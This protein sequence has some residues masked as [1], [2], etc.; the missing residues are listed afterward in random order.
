MEHLAGES[1]VERLRRGPVPLAQALEIAA[2]VAEALDAAHKHGIVHRDL[3]P[4]NVMLTTGG[5]GRSGA[6]SAKLLD[7]GLAK[8][9]GH[10][11]R[12]ALAGGVSAPTMTAPIT[13]RGT[14][15]GTLQYMAPEQLEGKEADARTDLWALGAILYE[16]V[17]GR[18][19]FE[20]ESQVSLIGNIMNA[21]PA[22][23]ATLQPLTPPA[24]DRVVKKCL[25]K[26]PDDRWDTAHDVADDLRW[27]AEERRLTQ[28]PAGGQ[29]PEIT[30]GVSHARRGRRVRRALALGLGAVVLAGSGAV[31][32]W[33]AAR[34]SPA[35]PPAVTRAFIDVRPAERVE[36]VPALTRGGSRTAL[37]ITQDGKRLVF[38]G[39]TGDVSRLYVRALDGTMA[40]E[41]KGT[42][43]AESPVFSPDGRWIAFW[44]G[45]GLKKVQAG[46]GP[47]T[48][49]CRID[50]VDPPY[51]ISWADDG[52][53]VFG[54]LRGGLMEVSSNGGTPSVLTKLQPG[55]VSHRLPCVMPGSQ[56]VL[57]TVRRSAWLWGSEE[58]VA[59]SLVTGERR[60]V[61]V[62]GTDARYVPT[63]H[64]VYLQLGTLMARAFDPDGLSVSGPPVGLVEQVAQSVDALTE[65]HVSGAGQYAVSASGTLV[66]LAGGIASPPR[67]ALVALDRTG[68]ITTLPVEPSTFIFSPVMS[69]DGKTVA[70]PTRDVTQ[71]GLWLIDVARGTRTR[72]VSEGE[73]FWPR[74]TPDG[75]RVA[76]LWRAGGTMSVAWVAADS[77]APP[78]R[79]V[80]VDAG[81]SLAPLSWSPDGRQ[82]VINVLQ[83]NGNRDISLLSLNDPKRALQPLIHTSA[84][85]INA[86]FSPDGKWLAYASNESGRYEVY[87][88]AH[89]PAGRRVAVSTTGA[90]NP[91]W[92]P[93]GRELFFVSEPDR[94]RKRWLMSARFTA[95]P[96][97]SVG[98]PRALFEVIFR[99]GT[100]GNGYDVFPDGERFLTLR[101]LPALP[102]AP[103]TEITL[104]DHWFEELKTK[105]PASGKAK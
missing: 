55:E 3:K 43:G 18:R 16:M 19:A 57:F 66:Y 41:L 70:V 60:V 85:E 26:H 53:I 89:P 83:P 63:G 93:N 46:G 4:G 27:I 44:A 25:A 6:V 95:R 96:K 38:V 58:I 40:S 102:T 23:L 84:N 2:Q 64:L 37:A 15:L 12:P 35:P 69:P 56:S 52:R 98:I 47:M 77:V 97:P 92:H 74:W 45:G 1:L 101:P 42:E 61:M 29:P 68:R 7:F 33:L 5:A 22:G 62:G 82:L 11:E 32:G 24:L 31:V 73:T 94:D 30:D 100:V 21:E 87:L 75:R 104:V 91:A 14:I 88:Q 99:P 78:E 81:G 90:L 34:S 80:T 76:F 79:L 103:V 54:L 49:I 67:S 86:A 8:L 9:T 59:H 10:G 39:R 20:G 71:F 50:S 13:E 105:V 65:P 36:S 72:V 28:T 48:S 51:G 17:T